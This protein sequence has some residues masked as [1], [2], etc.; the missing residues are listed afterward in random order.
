[1]KGN[2]KGLEFD[3]SSLREPLFVIYPLQGSYVLNESCPCSWCN[4]LKLVIRNWEVSKQCWRYFCFL[5]KSVFVGFC[6]IWIFLQ[7]TYYMEGNT[8]HPVFQTQFGTIAVNICY[9]RHHPLNWLMFSMNGAEI[10][11]NPSATIGKLR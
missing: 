5:K 2:G 7:S 10:I 9:G 3:L 8:G 11:F 4:D 6:F 1:M